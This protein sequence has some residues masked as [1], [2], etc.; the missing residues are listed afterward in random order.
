MPFNV[1]QVV[2]IL[3]SMPFLLLPFPIMFLVSSGSGNVHD[4]L[5][6]VSLVFTTTSLALDP[7]HNEFEVFL[8]SHTCSIYRSLVPLSPIHWPVLGGHSVT[9]ELM[10]EI[11][12]RPTCP[13]SRGLRA[14]QGGLVL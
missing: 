3:L 9:P 1:V 5:N 7:P 10:T 11:K 2:T 8:K 14:C 12:F 6:S 4:V 13:L